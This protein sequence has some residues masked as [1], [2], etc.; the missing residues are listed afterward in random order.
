MSYL[1]YSKVINYNTDRVTNLATLPHHTKFHT[2]KRFAG[3]RAQIFF[4]NT[5]KFLE[6]RGYFFGFK[7][8]ICTLL[9]DFK[10]SNNIIDEHKY[11]T[12]GVSR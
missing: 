1:Y 10:I 11:N 5:D 8:E 6:L 7:I 3:Q 4:H 9:K 12:S 2:D